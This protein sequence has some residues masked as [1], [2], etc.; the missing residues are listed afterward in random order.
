MASSGAPSGSGSS[1]GPIYQLLLARA[2]NHANVLRQRSRTHELVDSGGISRAARGR[3]QV[4]Q[5]QRAG[6]DHRNAELGEDGR[7][8]GGGRDQSFAAEGPR[9][10]EERR[11]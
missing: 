6:E 9:Q 3:G 8:E 7:E 2:A 5:G 1:I 4:G 10:D 11:Q